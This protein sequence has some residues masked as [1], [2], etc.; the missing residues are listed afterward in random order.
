VAE[1]LKAPLVPV[2]VNVRVPVVALLFTVTVRVEVPEPV[3]EVGLK[4]PVTRD[5]SPLTLKLTAPANPLV[6]VMVT[7][8]VP[9]DDR[10]TLRL[11]GE[12]EMVK[13]GGFTEFTVRVTVV[14]WVRA[15]E[16]PV[17][18][19]VDVPTVA[20]LLAVNVS[21]LVP[22]VLAGLKV[23][24]TP[25]G[26]PEAV[27][28]TL[29]VNPFSGLTVIVLVALPPWVTE[30]LLGDADS[31]KS[32]VAAPPQLGNLKLAMWVFQLNEPVVFM[33][34]LV[35]QKVQSSTG[36]ICMAL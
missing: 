26:R 15:P 13:F 2:I 18:V 32:G 17:M 6:P 30:T 34:S 9:D 5:G 20:V 28:L 22:V 36:S 10:A 12:T 24:V 14:V 25:A 21:V 7:V 31:E 23:A 1:W 27:R 35:Y 29:P 4:V 3:T 11:V 33:Y 16:V 8:Y 19:M